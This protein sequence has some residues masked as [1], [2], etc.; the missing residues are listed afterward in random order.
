MGGELLHAKS[1]HGVV[2]H[3]WVAHLITYW[4]WLLR[5]NLPLNPRRLDSSHGREHT[6]LLT[7]LSLTHTYMIKFNLQ[8]RHSKFC[9]S[10]PVA[11]IKNALTKMT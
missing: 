9:S 2:V 6:T 3:G 4:P 8:T 7:L 1:H 10:F 5:W 11:V